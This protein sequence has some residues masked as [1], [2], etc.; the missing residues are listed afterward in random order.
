MENEKHLDVASE[1]LEQCLPKFFVWRLWMSEADES[2][3]AWK[4]YSEKSDEIHKELIKILEKHYKD[5]E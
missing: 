5:G 2:G 1:I 4:L 3:M